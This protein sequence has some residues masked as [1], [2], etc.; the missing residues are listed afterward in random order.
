MET[1]FLQW[2]LYAASQYYRRA[3]NYRDRSDSCRAGGDRYTP[4]PY[5]QLY[6]TA[7]LALGMTKLP[8]IREFSWM[9]LSTHADW[10]AMA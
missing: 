1:V 8:Q 9:A 3:A 4:G 7:T 5:F 10:E 6:G 2:N